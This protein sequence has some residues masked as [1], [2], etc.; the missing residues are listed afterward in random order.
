MYIVQNI[1]SA[2]PSPTISTIWIASL[3]R[4]EN[5]DLWYA[6]V[7]NRKGAPIIRPVVPIL[8]S[9]RIQGR[10][11]QALAS[12]GVTISPAPIC[13]IPKPALPTSTNEQKTHI[14]QKPRTYGNTPFSTNEIT[15]DRRATTQARESDAKYDKPIHIFNP[16]KH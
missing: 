16:R 3:I 10:A 2:A 8:R 9:S 12:S 13:V 4:L 6:H 14:P 15:L 11:S 5:L 7:S 1:H